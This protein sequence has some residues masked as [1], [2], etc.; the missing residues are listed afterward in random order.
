MQQPRGQEIKKGQ[1]TKTAGFYREKPLGERQ[2]SPW[3]GEF[4]GRALG[5]LTLT[6]NPIKGRD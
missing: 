1:V 6:G 4:K 5:I 3:V 2:P